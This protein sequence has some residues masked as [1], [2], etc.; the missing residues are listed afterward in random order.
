MRGFVSMQLNLAILIKLLLTKK[1]IMLFKYQHER[2]VTMHRGLSSASGSSDDNFHPS[3]LPDLDLMGKNAAAK[4]GKL[5][6]LEGYTLGS[7]LD[8]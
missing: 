7:N 1:Q 8:K 5:K 6:A 3:K 4:P 2:A